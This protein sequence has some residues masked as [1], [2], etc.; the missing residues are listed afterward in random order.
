MGK[1]PNYLYYVIPV[2][3]PRLRPLLLYIDKT[4]PD[5]LPLDTFYTTHGLY[6]LLYIQWHKS[7]LCMWIWIGSL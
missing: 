6:H 7:H 4:D 3:I 2:Q 5:I 1:P